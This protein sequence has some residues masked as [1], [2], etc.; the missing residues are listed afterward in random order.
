[1]T[2]MLDT[3]AESAAEAEAAPYSRSRLVLGVLGRT[4][5]W[6]VAGCLLITLVP[7]LFGWRPYVV[8][9]GSM[10]PR[11]QVG[12]V[13]LASP[14]VDPEAVGGH[15]IVFQDP[16]HGT[17]THR[18]IGV[19]DDGTFI[20]KGDA[21]PTADP[22]PVAVEDID[23]VGRLLVRWAG[24]PLIWLQTGQWIKLMLFLLS[25]AVALA[26]VA[27]DREEPPADESGTEREGQDTLP[28]GE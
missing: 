16:A 22:R 9:S 18:V 13:V 21:N 5:L 14:D 7:V 12:D 11:I 17:V 6:F 8:E 3:A 27:R 24:L 4:W 2:Q 10:Q 15:I 19:N 20:T 23:G 28:F 1:M 25:L 26:A